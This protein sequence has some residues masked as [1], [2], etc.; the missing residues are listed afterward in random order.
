MSGSRAFALVAAAGLALAGTGGAVAARQA[1]TMSVRMTFSGA[2]K[3]TVSR[4]HTQ[5]AL[6]YACI[7]WTLPGKPLRYALIFADDYNAKPPSIVLKFD[8]DAASFGRAHRL[9]ASL[10]GVLVTT[11]D[12]K[13]WGGLGG[14]G[15][16]AAVTLG[17]DLRHGSFVVRNLPD[18]SGATRGRL[19]VTGSWRCAS[20]IRRTH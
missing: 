7:Q 11:P 18:M 17:R 5:N 1:K 2:Y 14:E 16:V 9:G 15:P 10:G 3:G 4:T 20:V 8:Y 19:N 6:T 13:Q 12:G